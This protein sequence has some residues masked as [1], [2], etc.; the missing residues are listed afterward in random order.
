M[1][2]GVTRLDGA[3][4][5]KQVWCPHVRTWG[6]SEANVLFWKKCFW[7]L[8]DFLAPTVIRPPQWFGPR[9]IGPSCTPRDTS[10][11][12]QQKSEKCPKINKLPTLWT[13]IPWASAIFEHNATWIL[14]RLPIKV[15]GGISS[16]FVK[17]L[18]HF[19]SCPTRFFG[20]NLCLFC[21]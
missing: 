19:E 1:C 14:Q 11:V 20:M 6:L 7:H 15:T 3:W 5:K 9:G 18:C 8:C 13:S 4:G 12:I 21:Y 16:F 10:G 2:R 17:F